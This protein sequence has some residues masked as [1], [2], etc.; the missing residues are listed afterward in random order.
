MLDKYILLSVHFQQ[1][2][3]LKMLQKHKQGLHF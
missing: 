1:T 2:L 3:E